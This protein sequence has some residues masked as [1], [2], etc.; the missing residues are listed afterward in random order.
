MKFR[1]KNAFHSF[2]IT[3]LFALTMVLLGNIR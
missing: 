1:K 2:W 3:I